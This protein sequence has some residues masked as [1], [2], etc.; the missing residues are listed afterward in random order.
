MLSRLAQPLG[1]PAI[2]KLGLI[3]R[4]AD[5]KGQE[6]V[7]P[8]GIVCARLLSEFAAIGLEDAERL[9]KQFPV[10]D[11]VMPTSR[12]NPS[13]VGVPSR[14]TNHQRRRILARMRQLRPPLS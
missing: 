10:Y 7:A 2:Q 5:V 4:A 3:A 1:E 11:A 14:S 8:E 9:A 6:A 13:D 12:V